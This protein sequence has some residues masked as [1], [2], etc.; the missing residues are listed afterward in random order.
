MVVNVVDKNLRSFLA[1]EDQAYMEQAARTGTM[2]LLKAGNGAGNDFL[3]WHTY[4]ASYDLQEYARVKKRR[5]KF[6][7]IRRCSSS[8][9][10]AVLI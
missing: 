7:A 1:A 6:A 10:L 2:P 8:S 3:G 5:K 9:V 4:P